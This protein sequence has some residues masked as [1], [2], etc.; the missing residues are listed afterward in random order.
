[1]F[2]SGPWLALQRLF[3][4]LGSD[5]A[6]A[7]AHLLTKGVLIGIVVW[8]LRSGR[9]DADGWTR[10][11]FLTLAGL[12]VLNPAVMPWYLAWA[13]P[14]AI[15]C[16]D[17]SWLIFTGLVFLSYLFYVDRGEAAWWLWVEYLLLLAAVMW[18][19]RTRLARE[20]V[21]LLP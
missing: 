2:N 8:S 7:W 19:S 11:C 12:V 4:N 14:F 5:S 13:L 1:M 3:E 21:H 20:R 18:E 16:G 10:A 9:F 15:A 17:R 6:G